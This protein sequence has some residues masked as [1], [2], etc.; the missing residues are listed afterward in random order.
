MPTAFPTADF[1]GRE[2]EL[3]RLR[4]AFEAHHRPVVVVHGEPGIGKTR[5]LREFARGV[6]GVRV[7]WGTCDP[8]RVGSPYAPWAEALGVL[9]DP[10]DYEA[11]AQALDGSVLVL[12]DAQWASP[13][14][15]ELL[16]HAARFASDALIVVALRGVEI[17]SAPLAVIARRRECVYIGLGSLSPDESVVLV[18][19]AAESRVGPDVLDAIYAESGGNPFFAQEL[20]RH[21]R[22]RDGDPSAPAWRPPVT[23]RR[24]IGLRLGE[25]SEPA[26]TMLG[27]AAVFEQGFGFRELETVT[28]FEEAQ[29]LDCLDEALEADLLRPAGPERYDFA[30]A[31]VRRALYARLAPSRRSRV[32][33]RLAEALEGR[34]ELAA[35]VARQYHASADLPGASRGVQYALAAA[36]AAG[37]P[38]DAARMLELAVDMLDPGDSELRASILGDLAYALAI[39][40][41][42]ADATLT[43]TDAVDV[44][45]RLG[46]D[47]ERLADL[48][49]R[50]SAAVLDLMG[51]P[52]SL[53]PLL[54]RALA[55]LGDERGLPWARLKL[56]ERPVTV[57]D[58]APV[59]IA[60]FEGFD[61]E[62][63]RI[64]RE[65]G[66]EADAARAVE[67]VAQWPLDRFEAYMPTVHRWR[68]PRAR[69][70]GVLLLGIN[71]VVGRWAGS[72][73]PAARLCAEIEALADLTGSP[74]ARASAAA[75]R[76]ALH[77]ARGELAQA[78][79]S[80]ARA[81]DA[82]RELGRDH[83][84][85][86]LVALVAD[87]TLVHV[88]PDWAD[89]G[90]RMEAF[91]TRR[92]P[93]PW[94]GQLWAA[95][96]AHAFARAGME[97]RARALLETIVPVL[98]ASSPWEEAQTG[99]VGFAA[100]AAWVLQAPDLARPLAGP[101]QA[102][103]E[104]RAGDFYMSNSSLALARVMALL[105]RGREAE[106]AFARARAQVAERELPILAA[107]VDH[108]EGVARRRAA[109]PDA[110]PLLAAA[111]ER[112]DMLGMTAW[113]ERQQASRERL[114]DALTPREVEVLR[115][116][117]A[118]RTNKEIAAE[119]VVSVHTV[120][121]H[122]ANAYRKISVRNRA[123]ATAYVLRAK[124]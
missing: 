20:A 52:L 42:P 100:E 119:L 51:S 18:E 92:E 109:S 84:A 46:T 12:D 110:E 97:E 105:G 10:R 33:R 79:A 59:R 47:G 99:A 95:I 45:E 102:V 7:L 82:L 30:H 38:A 122:L 83:R 93:G 21:L 37:E 50:V 9:A 49:Q 98:V 43:L 118:G 26:Q 55:A 25:L 91:A 24:A 13:E 111:A 67:E 53:Q 77:G 75:L 115:L 15:L 87:L 28:G 5:L 113:R 112:F 124:L 66:T 81:E 80:L 32:H 39:G 16:V 11:V 31:L 61:P 64:I 58:A 48:V 123:D 3:A 2:D 88:D 17:E 44:H 74:P 60:R 71:A 85:A 1:V 63:V 114:P 120:E 19:G 70:R 22:A 86:S 73:L 104:A 34:E 62:A 89:V 27:L 14:T 8:V 54:A 40:G 117:A 56:L 65:Q 23:I 101:V 76:T 90:E 116:V 36:E 72:A 121:R 107:I 96:G 108:D 29:L 4:D 78:R 94:A 35:E 57:I 41:H 103:V 68:D 106:A 6:S 69:L